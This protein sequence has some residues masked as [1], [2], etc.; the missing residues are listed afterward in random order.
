MQ[1][2][3]LI[4]GSTGGLGRAFVYECAKRGDNLFLTGTNVQRLEKI[5]I[6][7]KKDFPQIKVVSKTCDLSQQVQ[8]QEL[9][10][11]INQN[12]VCVNCLINN[13]GYIIEGEL[14]SLEDEQVI[15]AIRVNCEGTIDLTQKIIKARNKSQKLNI[16]TVS[17][18][19]GDYPMPN[20]SIYSATKAMLTNFMIALADELK[21]QNIVITTICP[22]GIPTTPAMKDA[23]KAQGAGG[24][25]T[26]CQPEQVAKIA[27]KANKRKKVVVIPKLINKMVNFFSIFLTRK[28]L[29]RIVGKRWK[30]ANKKRKIV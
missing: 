24:K 13:A 11:Y 28:Q 22:S 14:L 15:R 12:N 19:A 18:M 23:I 25:I 8:R 29:A 9:I 16:I 27:L 7:V 17:S 6:D 30:K 20:M 2:F 26:M 10:D 4:T 3:T 21:D 1:N 5:E